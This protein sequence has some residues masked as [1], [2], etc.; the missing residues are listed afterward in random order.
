MA[1]AEAISSKGLGL[2]AAVAGK[3]A[4]RSD[5]QEHRAPHPLR[6]RSNRRR[7]FLLARVIA[8]TGNMACS[9]ILNDVLNIGA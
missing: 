5:T 4:D 2:C 7:V 9:Q 3:A 8:P 1:M 6:P